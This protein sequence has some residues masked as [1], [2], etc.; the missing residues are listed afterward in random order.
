MSR[1]VAEGRSWELARSA[2]VGGLSA[3]LVCERFGMGEDIL[4]KR[5]REQGS[6]KRAWAAAQTI[7]RRARSGDEGAG[8]V[9]GP[10]S[11]QRQGVLLIRL[12]RQD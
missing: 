11:S 9:R 10:T 3:R 12:P 8:P 6:T 2:F 1:A 4:T 7:K 5:A